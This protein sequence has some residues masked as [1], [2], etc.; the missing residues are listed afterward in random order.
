MGTRKQS[1]LVIE[2]DEKERELLEKASLRNSTTIELFAK[3][4]ALV[5]ALERSEDIDVD[6]ESYN[7]YHDME[8]SD[9]FVER[10]D[11]IS[12]ARAEAIR[13]VG[14]RRISSGEV[15]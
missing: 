15:P 7:A 9:D 6:E 14:V 13:L 10:E 3:R 11:V 8:G 5:G 4:M 1:K 12:R 2:L